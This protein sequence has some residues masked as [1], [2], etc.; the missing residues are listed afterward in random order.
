MCSSLY[1]YIY[2]IYIYILYIYIYIYILLLSLL[3]FSLFPTKKQKDCEFPSDATGTTCKVKVPLPKF[4]T[5]CAYELGASGQT[6]KYDKDDK[7]ATW[8]LT[9]VSGGLSYYCKLKLMVRL[10]PFLLL[11]VSAQ[12]YCEGTVPRSPVVEDEPHPIFVFYICFLTEQTPHPK[13]YC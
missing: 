1:I 6:L 7:V 2:Y 13:V 4:T 9:K 3:L 5:S 10:D 8:D 11:V 12:R